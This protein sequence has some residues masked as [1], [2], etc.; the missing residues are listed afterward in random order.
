M[1]IEPCV[2]TINTEITDSG[3]GFYIY[4]YDE[5]IDRW[6]KIYRAIKRNS[7]EEIGVTIRFTLDDILRGFFH[8]YDAKYKDGIWEVDTRCGKESFVALGN[9]FK[10]ALEVIRR[11]KYVLPEQDT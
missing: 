3:V 2:D 1:N 4:T 11:I 5:E 8:N 6:L 10:A 7:D 9:T